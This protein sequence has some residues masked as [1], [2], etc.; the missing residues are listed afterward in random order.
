MILRKSAFFQTSPL[1]PEEKDSLSFL[2]YTSK[3]FLPA[4]F[5]LSQGKGGN[6]NWE[7]LTD[8]HLIGNPFSV[9]S[10]YTIGATS[11]FGFASLFCG[12][13]VALGVICF[14][15]SEQNSCRIKIIT[16]LFLAFSILIY[17]S[18]GLFGIFSLLKQAD[19]YWYRYSYVSI[20]GL[21]AVAS[22]NYSAYNG[23]RKKILFAACIALC[24]AQLICTKKF[25]HDHIKLALIGEMCLILDVMLVIYLS[26][27][28]DH[29]ISFFYKEI[30]CAI[31]SISV[32]SEMM[33]NSSLLIRA[34]SDASVREFERYE[35][36]EKELI[37]SI[38]N[39]DPDEYRMTQ[40]QTR[41]MNYQR[42]TA[43]FNESL[44]FNYWSV[45]QYTSA[46]SI[47][48]LEWCDKVGYQNWLN[49]MTVKATSIL[50]VDS[51]L[52]VKYVLSPYPINELELINDIPM[53]NGKQVYLNPYSLPFAFRVQG[54]RT[55]DVGKDPFEHI[56]HFYSS[57]LG[58][59]VAVFHPLQY[60]RTESENKYIYTLSRIED[61]MMCYGNLPNKEVGGHISIEGGITYPYSHFHAP[62]VFY[63]PTSA[64][65][66]GEVKVTLSLDNPDALLHEEFYYLDLEEFTEIIKQL[67][68]QAADAINIRNGYL[69]CDV[70]GG[71]DTYLVTS[72]SAEKGWAI[73]VNG[74]TVEPRLLDDTFYLIPLQEGNNHVEMIYRLPYAYTGAVLSIL[75]VSILL[76]MKRETKKS[77]R[78][79]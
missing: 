21:C 24:I 71:E 1:S 79:L 44:A 31:L 30:L 58:R 70:E 55:V 39:Y 78:R 40:L 42:T 62:T 28:T 67:K 15:V 72:I 12:S 57:L 75:A 73:N 76:L 74:V 3:R 8:Y 65:N 16:G 10:G 43:N 19:S 27:T 35:H 20:F 36:E 48:Q 68:I 18:N 22:E 60:S 41:S 14:F 23:N 25:Y 26:N 77:K 54:D 63:I 7:Y 6:L 46:A 61:T 49:S 33:L 32:I 17:Y 50:P 56:N 2:L 47:L 5:A 69:G 59:E 9:L 34:Y 64:K 38:R 11:R 66:N 45:E 29:T 51:F 52:G 53:K 13:L 4:V 37:S